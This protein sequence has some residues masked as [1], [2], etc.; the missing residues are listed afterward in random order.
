MLFSAFS[1]F[2]KRY[3]ALYIGLNL[4]LGSVVY[5]APSFSFVLPLLLLWGPLISQEKKQMLFGCVL[6]LLAFSY[7]YFLYPHVTLSQKSIHTTIQFSI[8]S[9]KRSASPFGE[10]YL[11]EG[12]AKTSFAKNLPV[13]LF[14]PLKDAR[15]PASKD[16]FIEGKLEQK[17]AYDYLFKPDRNIPWIPIPHTYSLAEIR[18]TCKEAVRSYIEKYVTEPHSAQFL[19]ALLT[20]DLNERALA[21][22]FSRLGVQHILAISGFHFALLAA[23]LG[24]WLRLIFSPSRCALCLLVLLTAYFFFLGLSPSVQ[25]AW[26]AITLVLLGQLFHMKTSGLNALG[27]GLTIEMLIDPLFLLHIGFQLSFLCTTAILILYPEVERWIEK[28]FPKRSLGTIAEMDLINQTGSLGISLLRSS[29]A[30]NIAVHLV[31]LLPVLY[32]FHTFPWLSMLY[33]LFFPFWVGISLVLFLSSTLV[34]LLLPPLGILLHKIS[35]AFTVALIQFASHPP[36]AFAF[37]WRCKSIPFFLVIFSLSL[38][39]FAAVFIDQK[40]FSPIK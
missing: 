30:L 4:L 28:L 24:F 16:Y 22:T 19:T 37:S 9:L 11:Y 34:H 23:F 25:R 26:I 18:H 6:F 32:I 31:S 39:F 8:S 15:P 38:Y 27:A 2:W 1:Y 35:S 14:V 13:R 21:F 12:R 29:L 20:G 36:S 5:L 10:S 33:N 40:R 17:D 7:A 3:P